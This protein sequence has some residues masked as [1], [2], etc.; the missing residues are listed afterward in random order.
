MTSLLPLVSARDASATACSGA[1]E[2]RVARAA[3]A[4]CAALLSETRVSRSRRASRAASCACRLR[5]RA[6]ARSGFRGRP[7][8]RAVALAPLGSVLV[9]MRRQGTRRLSSTRFWVEFGLL[10]ALAYPTSLPHTRESTPCTVYFARAKPRIHSKILGAHDGDHTGRVRGASARVLHS[11][12]TRTQHAV[13]RADAHGTATWHC[14]LEPPV[15]A[16]GWDFVPVLRPVD[17]RHTL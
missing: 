14:A 11:A 4:G 5:F 16:I 17:S 6:K 1:T 13:C 7:R 3:G 2:A 15:R 10:K 8:P 12:R 9:R